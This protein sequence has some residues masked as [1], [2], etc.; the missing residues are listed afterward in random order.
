M[1]PHI[2]IHYYHWMHWT[3]HWIVTF[4]RLSFLSWKSVPSFVD[5][6]SP[7]SST[8]EV[9]AVR[10]PEML[11][12]TKTVPLLYIISIMPFLTSGDD[13]KNFVLLKLFV[14]K[15]SRASERMLCSFYS[16]KCWACFVAPY[17][18]VSLVGVGGGTL[19]SWQDQGESEFMRRS[20]AVT[21]SDEVRYC[22][23]HGTE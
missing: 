1:A 10:S 9:E 14:R 19:L 3:N 2:Y 18:T 4:C 11:I 15:S 23:P 17:S 13:G 6:V 21:T 20:C 5:C 22:V 7:Q 12:T 16:Q 8:I